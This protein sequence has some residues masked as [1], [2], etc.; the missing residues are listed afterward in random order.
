LAAGVDLA[1]GE[2]ERDVEAGNGGG[3]TVARARAT[4]AEKQLQI[5]QLR[6]DFTRRPRCAAERGRRW[7]KQQKVGTED[8]VI[9][10]SARSRLRIVA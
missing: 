9:V 8:R 4:I 7:R 6:S 2:I 5:E 3:A 1:A 10:R